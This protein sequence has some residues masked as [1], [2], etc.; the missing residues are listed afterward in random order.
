MVR[1]TDHLPENGPRF[2][3]GKL[4]PQH[5]PLRERSGGGRWHRWRLLGEWRAVAFRYPSSSF[6]C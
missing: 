6:A 4:A 3:P 2:G 1:K 5:L